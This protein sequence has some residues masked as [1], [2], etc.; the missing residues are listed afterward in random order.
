M[1]D[2]DKLVGGSPHSRLD[3]L[4]RSEPFLQ[5]HWVNTQESCLSVPFIAATFSLIDLNI[6]N[7]SSSLLLLGGTFLAFCAAGRSLILLA[8]FDTPGQPSSEISRIRGAALTQLQLAMSA[9]VYL[10]PAN[11]SWS[12][13]L[14]SNTSINR[15]VSSK[16]RF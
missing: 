14:D 12:F 3:L 13:N 8:H 10:S 9:K 5:R 15:L 1:C 6:C 7:I 4:T 16:Y 11:Q 2:L